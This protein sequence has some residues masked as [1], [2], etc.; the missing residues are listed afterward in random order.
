MS[1][2]EIW[3]NNFFNM[4]QGKKN[5]KTYFTKEK[6]QRIKSNFFLAD[7]V[8]DIIIKKS[9]NNLIAEEQV[10]PEAIRIQLFYSETR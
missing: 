8:G 7:T 3:I 9:T 5:P 10:S 4:L 2:C 6:V 1:L